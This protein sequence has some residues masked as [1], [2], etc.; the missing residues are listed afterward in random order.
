MSLPKGT[1]PKDRQPVLAEHAE[2]TTAPWRVGSL[3][4]PLAG[5]YRPRATLWR[6]PDGRC[7]WTVRLWEYDRPVRHWLPTRELRAWAAASGLAELAGA[8]ER[9]DAR[10]RRPVRARQ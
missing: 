1:L 10:A 9:L 8:I 2:P 6:M 3:R 4:L 5:A 7:G